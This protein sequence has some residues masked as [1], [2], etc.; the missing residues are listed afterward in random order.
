MYDGG[1]S[2]CQYDDLKITEDPCNYCS[3]GDGD[4]DKFVPKDTTSYNDIN[5]KLDAI[6]RHFNIKV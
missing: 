6:M 1:C 2:K 5:A 3:N 4:Y